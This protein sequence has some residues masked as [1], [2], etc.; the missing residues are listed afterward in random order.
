MKQIKGV[1]RLVAVAL[2]TL[3]VLFLVVL[4]FPFLG[5]AWR[6]RLIRRMAPV[7]PKL[8]GVRVTVLGTLPKN[9]PRFTDGVN[10]SGAGLLVV[11][12]HVSIVDI[13][14]LDSILPCRFVAKSE[15]ANWPVFGLIARSVG[16]LFIERARRRA[17]LD[18]VRLMSGT[19][20][21][22]RNVV[23]FPEGTTGTGLSLL[24]F[25]ANLFEAA[26]M[27]ETDILPITLNYLEDGV[28]TGKASY[29][30]RTSMWT[31]MKRLVFSDNITLEI[32]VGDIIAGKGKTR[33]ALCDEA[34]A[35]M[36]EMLDLPDATAER[37]AARLARTQ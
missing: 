37:E 33:K 30:G 13:F 35:R 17:V 36:S 4:V 26:V 19:L 20:A 21:D 29:A 22:G 1:S 14:A 5:N 8:M 31:V 12:N 15:I 2:Y 3:W 10:P 6:G 25:H 9:D 7:L 24:P 11:A 34:S 32:H 18:T 27:S 16:S 28:R 23:F